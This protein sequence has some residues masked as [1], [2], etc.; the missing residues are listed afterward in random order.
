MADSSLSKVV[1]TKLPDVAGLP[2]NLLNKLKID[3]PVIANVDVTQIRSKVL[4]ALTDTNTNQTATSPQF[5]S[6]LKMAVQGNNTNIVGQVTSISADT[7]K[8]SAILDSK[9]LK[10]AQQNAQI[11]SFLSKL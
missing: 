10:I 2:P 4:G 11:D 5:T 6:M 8:K 3:S 9:V 7:I 1:S